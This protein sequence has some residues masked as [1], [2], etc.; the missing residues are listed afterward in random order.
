MSTVEIHKAATGG[1]GRACPPG[2]S[3]VLSAHRAAG[4]P[5]R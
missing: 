2:F 5:A 3:M 1:R 4:K